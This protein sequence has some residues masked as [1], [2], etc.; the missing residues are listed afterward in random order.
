[1]KIALCCDD[2]FAMA[3]GTCML[4]ILKNNSSKPI[5]FFILCDA[6]SNE[7]K[8]RIRTIATDYNSSLT[9]IDISEES[10]S[11][12]KVSNIFP[13]AIYFRFLLP[14]LI[15]NE[16]KILYLDCD[17]IVRDSLDELWHSNLDNIACGMVQDQKADDI[18]HY[19]RLDL[20]IDSQYFNSGVILFNLSFWRKYD[21]AAKCVKF[22]A[23][24]PNK[25]LY[26]DQDAINVILH[27]RIHCLSFKYNFQSGLL[28]PK[29]DIFLCKSNWTDIDES[30]ENP[31]IVHFT[32]PHKPW[33]KDCPHIYA[34]E[35]VRYLRNTPWNKHKLKAMQIRP[36]W[37]RA[38]QF[39]IYPLTKKYK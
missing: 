3:C 1:M 2:K 28:L 10:F 23:E 19:N 34:S 27:G 22:I 18:R 37:Y 24:N 36:W 9:L 11:T 38:L 21:L 35:W 14:K 30:K 20:P 32:E 39:V 7:A 33:Y 26:P 5:E 17:T 25:C 31:I 6:V 4:S 13:R 15:L 29:S 12:L 16:S 8:H